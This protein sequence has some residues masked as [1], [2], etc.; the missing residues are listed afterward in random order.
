MS[1][2]LFDRQSDWKSVTKDE[3]EAAIRDIAQKAG[4][5]MGAWDTCMATD[6]V[7]WRVQAHTQLAREVGVRSTP[8][9]FVLGYSP[10]QGALPIELFREVLDTVLVLEAQKTGG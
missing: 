1:H 3:G 4:L 9:F 5:E 6:A 8:T 10:I 2:G 7:L